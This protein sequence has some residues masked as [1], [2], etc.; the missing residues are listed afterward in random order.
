[1]QIKLHYGEQMITL[2]IPED[3]IA[4]I[5]RPWQSPEGPDN[6]TLLRHALDP[7]HV[8][9]FQQ[10]ISG[11][12]LCILL[13]DGTRDMPLSDIAAELFPLLTGAMHIQFVICTGTHNANTPQNEVIKNTITTAAQSA[14]LADFRLHT[15]DHRADQLINAGKTSRGT[16]ILFNACI[17]DA[18]VFLVLSDVKC[19]YFG[20]YSNPVKNFI[21]GICA[22][23]TAEQNH[24]LALDE[25]STFGLHPWHRN[26]TRRDNP[27]AADQLEGMQL[28]VKQ[29]PLFALLTIS[30]SSK[31]QWS[32]FGTAEMICGKA[33]D[34][35]DKQN[36]HTVAPADRLIV[37]PG[38][39]P[40]DVDLYISQRALELTKQAVKDGGEILFLSACPKGVGEEH[41]KE[42]FYNRLT[43]PIDKILNSIE[44]DYKLYSHK[45]YKFAQMIKRLNKIWIHS[46]IPDEQIKAAHLTPAPDP[47][48][49]VNNWLK[50]NPKTKITIVDGANKIAIYTKQ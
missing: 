42:N 9:E 1:M 7:R 22:Y 39:L 49:V 37:S 21:P 23:Q 35:C 4:D 17:Q 44:G 50:E 41:T 5:I 45:P 32:G 11:K 40:N 19:H 34:T 2:D 10:A 43:N 14:G 18:D 48:Q 8:S 26:E 24:S 25:N 30:T 29:R 47:Q 12:R 20:G 16:D 38:G 28:I 6:K 15:H 3:N 31:I 36:A 33:F 27:L 13:S 46:Q